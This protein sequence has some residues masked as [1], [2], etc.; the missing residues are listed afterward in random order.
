MPS[1]LI[2]D[3]SSDI[4]DLLTIALQKDYTVQSASHGRM[5]L[6]MASMNPQP[7]LILLDIVMPGMDGYEVCR[8]LKANKATQTIPVIFI[9]AKDDTRDEARGFQLGG[10]DFIFKPMTPAYVQACVKTHISL[11]Q[12][13][14]E[15]EKNNRRLQEINEQLTCNMEQLAASEERFRSLV[16][17]LPDIVYKIDEDG[18]F[19]FLNKSVEML[20]YHPS[21]LIGKHFTQIINNPDISRSSLDGV[22]QKV[23]PGVPNPD[24]HKVFNER[25]TGQRMTTAL[26]VQIKTKS[27][28]SLES[29]ELRSF[30]DPV[31]DV[32]INSSGIYGDIGN[33]THYRARR[34]MGT[35]GV[36]RN[37]TERKKYLE[38]LESVQKELVRTKEEA[39]KNANRLAMAL[40][41]GHLGLWDIN[42]ATGEQVI[43]PTEARIYGFA[44]EHMQRLREDW[45]SRL[46]PEDRDWVLKAGE[47]Y[48]NGDS[49]AYDLEFRII[50]LVG[51]VKWVHSKGAAVEWDEQGHVLR[52]VGTVSDITARKEMEAALIRAKEEAEAASRA[53]GD[54]LA[55]ISHEIRTPM[56]AVMGLT[57]LCL[58]TNLT[59]QQTD[60]LKK[61]KTSAFSLMHLINDILDFSK[62]EAGKMSMEQEAFSVRELLANLESMF[63]SQCQENN[64]EL[65]VQTAEDIPPL[66]AGDPFRLGQILTNL[67]GNAIKFTHQGSVSV[68]TRLLTET[69]TTAVLEFAVHDT[70]IGLTDEQ[71]RNLF[72]DFF[73][74]DASTTR[75]YGGTGLGLA[76]SRRLVEMMG[77]TI[78]AES[79]PNVG[80]R[81][82]FDIHL[83]KPPVESKKERPSPL[84]QPST[85]EAADTIAIPIHLKGAHVLLVEDND[86]NQQI[87]LEILEQAGIRVTLAENGEEAVKAT[88]RM[89]FDAIL[90]DI[91]MPVMDGLTSTR[92]IRQSTACTDVP[93]IAMTANAMAEDRSKCLA[94]GMNDHIA[95]PID[96]DTLFAA[97]GKRVKQPVSSAHPVGSSPSEAKAS[98]K[99]PDYVQSAS[100]PDLPGIDTRFGLRNM[101]GHVELY[102][103][104]LRK[105]IR[106]QGDICHQMVTHLREGNREA[107]SRAAHTL[108]GVAGTL[109]ITLLGSMA[110]EI[111]KKI[112]ENSE[113][114]EIS[115]ILDTATRELD[116]VLSTIQT[117]LP[118]PESTPPHAEAS[119]KGGSSNTEPREN[120]ELLAGHFHEAEKLLLAYDASVE[121]VIERISQLIQTPE[122]RVHLAELQ[123][124]LEN[125][126]FE[127]GLSQLRQWATRLD[128]DLEERP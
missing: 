19:T 17:M 42:F 91:Q 41:N 66:L 124:S 74:A 24:N 90:M 101:G 20:G 29:A 14:E 48:R 40:H 21:D 50:P 102:R 12:A 43:D 64:I 25:R 32:E 53:K 28:S 67:M 2:V 71:L 38:T 23:T 49:D 127:G 31:V 73:Q 81:F 65:R 58:K 97:L 110:A 106:N 34:Y 88:Q 45:V 56:N 72:Q 98:P 16:Q 125:Y 82:F 119:P 27:G 61:V 89:D 120:R 95:K 63:I 54:F 3:D 86:I 33:D 112:K 77:G 70:G 111:E 87:A 80:S 126:D 8:Q 79:S 36:I 9:T 128:I 104:V 35:V 118:D 68:S 83:H 10:V 75:K 47:R 44:P 117:A 76:I 100:V 85:N 62:I 107:I 4:L 51:G 109:G 78:R 46:H 13:R 92:L 52:M 69:N 96:P 7:D 103:K 11:R 37:I 57:N 1:I 55:N 122:M 39:E 30:S 123:K 60:Y 5:A 93:I 113:T 115:S 84:H 18:C 15:L 116:Q 105:F 26:E 6:E 121:N 114:H 22:L 108:K 94:V 99:T 59:R